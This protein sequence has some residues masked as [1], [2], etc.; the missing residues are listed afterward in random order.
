[1]EGVTVIQP[2]PKQQ[3]AAVL[4]RLDDNEAFVVAHS[5]FRIGRE[6]RCDLLIP[7]P[8]VSRLHAEITFDRGMYVLRDLGR[9]AS[10]VND[11]EIS[12]PQRLQAGDVIQIGDYQFRFQLRPAAARE[13][14]AAAEVTPVMSNVA[15]APTMMPTKKK[16][17]GRSY[18]W[19]FLLAA[20]GFAVWMLMNS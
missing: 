18:L 20:A 8:S 11:R 1:M 5:G 4:T 10:R 17:G 2:G 6:K 15:D 3:L 7:D 9:V 16:S 14:A 13:F 19:L 12:G